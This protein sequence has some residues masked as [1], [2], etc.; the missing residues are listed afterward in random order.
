MSGWSTVVP[1]KRKPKEPTHMPQVIGDT[2]PNQR[3]SDT[4]TKKDMKQ[5][6]Q[7]L[8]DKPVQPEVADIVKKKR[9]R[10][11]KKRHALEPE[12]FKGSGPIP[13]GPSGK[14][15]KRLPKRP[16]R[17]RPTK[18]RSSK[19]LPVRSSADSF[20]K[21]PKQKHP[22]INLHI[23]GIPRSWNEARL[24]KVFSQFGKIKGTHIRK[25]R[26]T[27]KHMGFGFVS[28]TNPKEASMAQHMMQGITPD[29]GR[30]GLEIKLDMKSGNARMEDTHNVLLKELERTTPR[31]SPVKLNIKPQVSADTNTEEL[32]EIHEQ[33][34][35]ED[36]W[37]TLGG[38]PKPA[39]VWAARPKITATTQAAPPIPDPGTFAMGLPPIKTAAAPRRD[40]IDAVPP[41]QAEGPIQ[42]TPQPPI[43]SRA[44]AR[45]QKLSRQRQQQQT[46]QQRQIRSQLP[47]REKAETW[48]PA[49]QQ[50]IRQTPE[51]G[52]MAPPSSLQASTP[53]RTENLPQRSSRM[54]RKS[55]R[56]GNQ[57][58][59]NAAPSAPSYEMLALQATLA[60]S[61]EENAKL[62][63]KY[64]TLYTASE[65]MAKEFKELK[66]GY[67]D[68]QKE[69]VGKM[70]AG[71]DELATSYT[72]LKTAYT[73]LLTAYN[74][75]QD[76]QK[77]LKLRLIAAEQETDMLRTAAIRNMKGN[78]PMMP[79]SLT[80]SPNPSRFFKTPPG[81]AIG[82]AIDSPKKLSLLDMG[83]WE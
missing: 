17:T 80:I 9:G 40:I 6:M 27:G 76:Q 14:T 8:F 31:T 15:R 53:V 70:T 1:K 21:G 7:Y 46:R 26:D 35:T 83:A 32:L 34:K 43:M 24:E 62:K 47:Q 71:Y 50:P 49:Q 18:Q 52:E 69:M 55:K 45:K 54:L 59:V 25:S 72:A 66:A 74:R 61:N 44:A 79:A 68:K 48:Q 4:D 58:P 38:S 30:K 19:D 2:K 28:F 65:N 64:A 23:R 20:K 11:K 82:S 42:H 56:G 12:L 3:S 73:E 37:P 16:P 29:G 81:D 51:S 13:T 63:L 10:Q 39:N 36:D 77:G 33:M 78:V 41:P 67:A 75:S 60:Q 57:T 5:K 22:T